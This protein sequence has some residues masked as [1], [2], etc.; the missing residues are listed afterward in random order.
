MPSEADL[1]YLKVAISMLEKELGH[2]VHLTRL[3]KH[4][5][6]RLHDNAARSMFSHPTYE[7]LSDLA[8]MVYGATLILQHKEATKKHRKAYG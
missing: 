2:T 4:N 3:G 5:A 1:D 6:F 8:L 7:T